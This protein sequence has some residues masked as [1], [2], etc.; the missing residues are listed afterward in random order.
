M[1]G[2]RLKVVNKVEINHFKR[3]VP[4]FVEK[5]FKDTGTKSKE[6]VV[7][8]YEIT[9][10]K[11]HFFIDGDVSKYKLK[12]VSWKETE[13]DHNDRFCALQ[14]SYELFELSNED[15]EAF[16][17][18]G[19]GT[20]QISWTNY[21][22]DYFDEE[23]IKSFALSVLQDNDIDIERAEYQGCNSNV[24]S[25]KI[26]D[27][28]YLISILA[29]PPYEYDY[30]VGASEYKVNYS[31]RQAFYDKEAGNRK[32]DFIGCGEMIDFMI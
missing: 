25:I 24:M 7:K 1:E 16:E 17:K 15:N 13:V 12:I 29:F 5:V 4:E 23:S 30:D 8:S 6:V 27:V 11:L 9:N 20:Y 21:F 3:W 18:V 32:V 14:L 2:N 10:Y 26:N 19:N 22:E 28:D 31:L